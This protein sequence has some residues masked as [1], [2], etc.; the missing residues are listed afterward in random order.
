MMTPAMDRT[1]YWTPRALV[2]AFAAFISIFA[3]DAFDGTA[4]ALATAAA[5]AMHLVPTAI[6]ALLLWLAWRREMVGGTV[7]AALGVAY[8]IAF[9]GRFA[10]VA[11]VAIAG[12]LVVAGLLFMAH[13]RLRA[14]SAT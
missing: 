14:H 3:L 2:I 8:C 11:Y 5:F 12:P 7:L 1:L 6:V 13:A 10:W 9:W 4:G